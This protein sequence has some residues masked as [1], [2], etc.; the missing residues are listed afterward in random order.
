MGWLAGFDLF[1]K[2]TC[3][4]LVCS[5]SFDIIEGRI[6]NN[7][8]KLKINFL[9]SVSAVAKSEPGPCAA[10]TQILRAFAHCNIF[11]SLNYTLET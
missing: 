10:E 8:F 4:Y 11:F 7:P 5:L 3:P 1:W 9:E 2:Q 6:R